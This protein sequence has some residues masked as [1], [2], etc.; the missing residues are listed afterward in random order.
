MASP[1][2][3]V[4]E[5]PKTYLV[6]LALFQVGGEADLESIAVKAHELFPG[7]FCWR[8]FRQYP[9]KDAVRVHLSEAK[10]RSFGGLVVDRDLR[11]ESRPEGGY[12]K[13]FALTAAGLQKAQELAGM[14]ETTVLAASQNPLDYRRLIQ[15]VLESTA[16]RQFKLGR[17][18]DDI[19]RDAFLQAFK[20]FPDAAEFSVKGRLVRAEAVADLI[21]DTDEKQLF[22]R[23]I[24]EGRRVH[25]L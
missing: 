3:S 5:V 4:T 1:P 18:H 25:G 10:K 23:F 21:S 22:I 24:K 7:Q 16:F 11:H 20:L 15:P 6:V 19:S 9:D 17:S 2:K 14:L 13:R 12:T 8:N